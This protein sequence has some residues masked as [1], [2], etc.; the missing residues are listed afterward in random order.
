MDSN[1]TI[2]NYQ[3]NRIRFEQ[4]GSLV[5]ANLNDMAAIAGKRLDNWQRLESTK[6]FLEALEHSLGC[7]VMVSNVGGK[8]ETT[9]T[10]GLEEVA[11]DFAAWCS[12]DLKIWMYQQIKVLLSTGKV[13]LQPEQIKDPVLDIETFAG[14]AHS[15]Y[16]QSLRLLT[17]VRDRGHYDIANQ[18]ERRLGLPLSSPPVN[19]VAAPESVK[20]KLPSDDGIAAWFDAVVHPCEGNRLEGHDLHEDYLEFSKGRVGSNQVVLGYNKFIQ[21]LK[22]I[23]PNHYIKARSERVDGVTHHV[24]S[25]WLDLNI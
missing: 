5:S 2:L 14:N 25:F 19:A 21:K 9:G 20:A 13:E 16:L 11:L 22:A 24:P 17:D 18:L 3:A 10:W 15:Q 23:A 8:P 1:I 6:T 7:E 4:R 12:V